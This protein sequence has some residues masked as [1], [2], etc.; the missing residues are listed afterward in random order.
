MLLLGREIFH[1]NI[2][3]KNGISQ[4]AAREARAEIIKAYSALPADLVW[5]FAK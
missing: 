4:K 2:A 1:W 5:S 3:K